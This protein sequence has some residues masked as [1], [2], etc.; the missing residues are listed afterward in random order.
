MKYQKTITVEAIQW[1][2]QEPIEILR[3][4]FNARIERIKLHK[5]YIEH[6]SLVSTA[7][8]GDYIVRDEKGDIYAMN[9]EEFEGKFAPCL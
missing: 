9:R 6:F 3:K 2:N 4:G 1:N 7:K 8:I 5:L